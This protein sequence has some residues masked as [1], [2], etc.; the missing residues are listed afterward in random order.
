MTRKIL[1]TEDLA[2]KLTPKIFMEHYG[3]SYGK[4]QSDMLKQNCKKQ[5]YRVLVSQVFQV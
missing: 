4:S 3:V 2:V 1:K 5:C